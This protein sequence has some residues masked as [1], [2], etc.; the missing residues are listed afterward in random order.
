MFEGSL[1]E[2][3]D[4]FSL[5]F[6]QPFGE[7]GPFVLVTADLDFSD[8]KSAKIMMIIPS[9]KVR[10]K[11]EKTKGAFNVKELAKAPAAI[12]DGVHSEI[13]ALLGSTFIPAKDLCGLE[14]GDVI[15]LDSSVKN[16]VPIY[17]DDCLKLFGQPGI[18]NDKLGVKVFSSG[19]RRAERFSPPA[20]P[21]ASEFLPEDPA[22]FDETSEFGQNSP[23]EGQM[24][25]F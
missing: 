22:G 23:V 13:K 14:E 20:V 1:I 19:A 4:S 16:L 25:H 24:A 8:V 15:L 21:P 2:M 6:D 7:N 12:K 17:V 11:L 3:T 9:A 10:Q 18:K 5:S